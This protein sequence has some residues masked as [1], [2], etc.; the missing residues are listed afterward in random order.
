VLR[1]CWFCSDDSQRPDRLGFSPKF[2][3]VL[4]LGFATSHRA[5]CSLEGYV[6]LKS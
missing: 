3:V 2:P 5:R 4:L 1:N 6:T